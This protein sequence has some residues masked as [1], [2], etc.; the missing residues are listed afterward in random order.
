M[1]SAGQEVVSGE[2]ERKRLVRGCQTM[3]SHENCGL[4]TLLVDVT[5][6]VPRGLVRVKADVNLVK[7]STYAAK[8]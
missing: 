2:N 1:C 7:S 8:C 6:K 3:I 4:L 5:E